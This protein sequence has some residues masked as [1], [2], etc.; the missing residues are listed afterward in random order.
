MESKDR[1]IS[2][3]ALCTFFLF[4]GAGEGAV[5]EVLDHPE[6]TVERFGAGSTIFGP[7][8]A[9]R[10]LGIF[11][12][13]MAQ[14]EKPTA[15]GKGVALRQMRRG[16]VF[17]AAT[18]FGSSG[19]YVTQIL[20][21]VDCTVL[22]LPQDAIE[23]LLQKYPVTARNYIEF[24]SDRIRFLNSK[25]DSFTAQGAE[26]RLAKYLLSQPR[27]AGSLVLTVSMGRLANELD[28]GR[29]SLYRAFERLIDAGAIER[30]GKTIRFLD[31]NLLVQYG[32]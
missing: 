31:E 8:T 17:G 10:C 21:V 32:S 18:L 15:E 3:S 30:E 23:T 22:F 9:R 19:R 26:G 27:T 20:A 11:L 25:I 16:D 28:I 2:F 5:N 14:V 24:L 7:S 13:G 29:A 12:N 1:V 6:V 4:R